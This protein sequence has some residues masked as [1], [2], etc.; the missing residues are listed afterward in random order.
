MRIALFVLGVALSSGAVAGDPAA[1]KSKSVTC[2]ACHGPQGISANPIWP[3]L[4]G[5]KEEYLRKQMRDFRDGRRRDPTMEPMAKPLSDADI[6]DLA[7][8]YSSLR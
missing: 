5:Q 1:G 3:N 8:Y 7:A 6:N 4:A 2:S